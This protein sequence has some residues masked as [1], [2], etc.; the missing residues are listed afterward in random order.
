MKSRCPE[1]HLT[2]SS[3]CEICG[4]LVRPMRGEGRLPTEGRVMGR[5]NR[6]PQTPPD[7]QGANGQAP[8]YGR[9]GY[10]PQGGPQGGPPGYGRPRSSWDD[11][12]GGYESGYGEPRNGYGPGGPNGYAPNG[13]GP[14]GQNGYGPNGQNGQNGQNGYGPGGP[15]GYGPNGRP[16]NGQNGRPAPNGRP[17]GQNGYG[18]NGRPEG[19]GPNGYGQPRPPVPPRPQYREQE[20]REG[21]DP[22]YEQ[23]GYDQ[24]GYEQGYDPQGYPGYPA[25]GYE[26]GYEQGYREPAPVA[27]PP[28]RP[29]ERPV[30]PA[31]PPQ[32]R[33]SAPEP[34]AQRSVWVAEIWVD[35]DWYD[36]QQSVEPCPPGGLVGLVPLLDESLL[37]GRHSKSLEVEPGI[38][39]G[40]DHGA[41]RRHAR[42][43]VEDGRW[44][45]E[46][47]QSANGTFVRAAGEPLPKEPVEAGEKVALVPGLEIFV[48]AWT[49]LAVRPALPD[50]HFEGEE[51]APLLAD[52]Q[53]ADEYADEAYDE[54][55]DGYA[56]DEGYDGEDGEYR[57]P[58]YDRQYA[59]TLLPQEDYGLVPNGQNGRPVNGQNGR[60]ASNG[61]RGGAP[62]GPQPAPNGGPNGRPGPNG[63]PPSSRAR[64]QQ[65][66]ADRARGFRTTPRD[67]EPDDGISL[68]DWPY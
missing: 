41:S 56:Y 16:P 52:D 6:G 10:G 7:G 20:Y 24:P 40:A 21:Y 60:P 46:D 2:S 49:R 25:P 55:D 12:R 31:R 26:P 68:D 50:E 27:R 65:A 59:S 37:V 22:G 63:G 1:G 39:C 34:E 23:P 13:R 15:N 42:V 35:P 29:A 54:Y 48:G 32:P 43:F 3:V 47:L 45:V 14:N 62:R 51:R 19:Y 11:G 17:T 36:T 28:A 64:I 8:G 57:G 9:G 33:P 53:P 61:P 5:R 67:E 44:W 58:G 30:R 66:I 4:S 18:P 38:D